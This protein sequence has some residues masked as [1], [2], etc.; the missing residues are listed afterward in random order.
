MRRRLAAIALAAALA[1]GLWLVMGPY[2]RAA[3]LLVLATEIQGWPRAIAR[4]HER[5]V[6]ERSFDIATRHRTVRARA[7]HPEHGRWRPVLVLSG[8]HPDGIDDPRLIH[9][10]RTLAA[11][12]LG[13]I[14]PELPGLFEFEV[15][16]DS[17]DLIED[18]TSWVAA[19][20]DLG[21][22]GRVGMVGISFSG[23]LAIV[24][25]GREAVRDRVAFVLSIGGHGD[26]LRTLDTLAGGI[27]TDAADAETDAFGLAMVLASAAD[28]VVPGAQVAPLRAWARTFL[29]AGHLPFDDPERG[30]LFSEAERLRAGLPEPAATFA[31]RAAEAD[32][33]AL[34][35]HLLHHVRE[36]AGHPALS[37]ERAPPPRAPVYLL[38]GMDDPVIPPEESR[39]LGEH[40]RPH[41]PVRVLLTPVLTHADIED[42]GARDVAELLMFLGSLLRR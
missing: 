33:A 10:A 25:A 26:L 16:P 19:H 15:G 27:L 14:T 32:S 36:L 34:R 41:V 23:G 1:V 13:A 11:V 24:A 28:R 3:A 5:E 17:T 35:P 42:P 21:A 6:V 39:R 40:L 38:H 12:G 37:P 30:Q 8:V 2:G 4:I 18:A 29:T 7:Y 9:F 22:G 31:A 20:G